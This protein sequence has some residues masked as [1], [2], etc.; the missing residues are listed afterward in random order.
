MGGPP[1]S[2]GPAA[3]QR[4]EGI[5]K[6]LFILLVLLHGLIH[7]M[8]FAK[9]FDLAS[10]EQLRVPISPAVGLLWLAA[11]LLFVASALLRCC[12]RSS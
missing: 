8:G 3:L 2:R 9:A 10:F 4:R 5:V 1:I 12:S 6:Y 7:L 11:A